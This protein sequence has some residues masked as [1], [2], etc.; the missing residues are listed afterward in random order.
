MIDWFWPRREMKA[1]D[2]RLWPI[3]RPTD[4]AHRSGA[5]GAKD[6]EMRRDTEGGAAKAPL[7]AGARLEEHS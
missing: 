4:P 2:H 6:R 7:A 3:W 1:D 5:H